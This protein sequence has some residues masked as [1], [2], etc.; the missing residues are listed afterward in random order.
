MKM[1]TPSQIDLMQEIQKHGLIICSKEK[2]DAYDQLEEKGVIS[3]Y[4]IGKTRYAEM[5]SAGVIYIDK[6]KDMKLLIKTGITF[7]LVA[8]AVFFT[9][10]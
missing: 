5:T 6:I 7:L 8:L 3:T 9:G 2:T 4:C 10:C 1:L